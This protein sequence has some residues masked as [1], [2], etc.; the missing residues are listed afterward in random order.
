[1]TIRT[2]TKRI[3]LLIMGTKTSSTTCFENS[4]GVFSWFF[5]FLFLHVLFKLLFIIDKLLVWIYRS[6]LFNCIQIGIV[7]QKIYGDIL[8]SD[9]DIFANQTANILIFDVLGTIDIDSRLLLNSFLN[10]NQSIV[11][12]CLI[13]THQ[14]QQEGHFRRNIWKMLVFVM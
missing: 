13:L 3:V 9:S 6:I 4:F 8:E 5:A 14:I 12:S 10:F 7:V 1:M 11:Y 2:I